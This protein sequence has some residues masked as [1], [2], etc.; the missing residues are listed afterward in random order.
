M[1]I[2]E[3]GCCKAVEFQRFV[4]KIAGISEHELNAHNDQRSYAPTDVC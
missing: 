4:R 2:F 1:G 3:I